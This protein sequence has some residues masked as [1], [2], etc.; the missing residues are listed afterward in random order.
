MP[1]GIN[2]KKSGVQQFVQGQ[3]QVNMADSP[4]GKDLARRRELGVDAKVPQ[5]SLYKASTEIQAVPD[6]RAASSAP[7]YVQQSRGYED[8]GGGLFDESVLDDS[9]D[10][11]RDSGSSTTRGREPMM[12][13]QGRQDFRGENRIEQ[14][15]E[16]GYPGEYGR[17]GEG[18]DYLANRDGG[19]DGPDEEYGQ[20]SGFPFPNGTGL[21]SNPSLE[22]IQEQVLRFRESERFADAEKLHNSKLGSSY[23]PPIQSG[24]AGRFTRANTL[25]AD[26]CRHPTGLGDTAEARHKPFSQRNNEVASDD[27]AGNDSDDHIRQDNLQQGGQVHLNHIERTTRNGLDSEHRS[28]GRQQVGDRFSASQLE[29]AYSGGSS[30]LSPSQHTPR[31][32]GPSNKQ[33]PTSSQAGKRKKA[34]LE[35]DYDTNTLSN[36]N[37]SELKDQPF[38]SNPKAPPSVI[39]EFLSSPEASLE[40]HLEYFRGSEPDDQI[41]FFAQMSLDQWE[42]SGDWFLG[43]FGDIMSKLK[44]AR[45]AKRDVSKTFEEELATREEAVRCKA[46]GIQEVFRQMRAGGE[47]VLRGRTS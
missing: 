25:A 43:R 26:V 32:N 40:D 27:L 11:T 24:I 2:V 1:L 28:S 5:Q 9:D 19:E 17:D 3:A 34:D 37:Y 14:A 13:Y 38:D 22:A 15:S 18:H 41:T 39:P 44:E 8:N 45:R 10:T 31:A 30:Q 7:R 20:Y 42:Q 12:P 29:S 21:M 36:M 47:G 46:E 23:L 33:T 6:R 35:L 4:T 16:P